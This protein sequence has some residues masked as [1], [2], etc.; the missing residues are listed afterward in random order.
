MENLRWKIE[1]AAEL[2][3]ME[4]LLDCIYCLQQIAYCLLVS[5]RKHKRISET[6]KRFS[7]NSLECNQL[8]FD[9]VLVFIK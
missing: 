5:Q 4:S 3:K 1:T 8:V 2:A 6:E 9:L 7:E